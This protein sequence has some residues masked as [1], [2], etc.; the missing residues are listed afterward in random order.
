MKRI[1]PLAGYHTLYIR[2]K[3][4]ELSPPTCRS[5]WEWILMTER[6]SIAS[7]NPELSGSSLLLARLFLIFFYLM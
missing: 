7:A 4:S 1:Y 2:I 6:P 3:I 5:T